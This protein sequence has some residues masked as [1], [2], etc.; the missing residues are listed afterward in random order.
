MY[1]KYIL[2]TLKNELTSFFCLL[3]ITIFDLLDIS[4]F[5]ADHYLY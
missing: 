4:I 3:F 2:H 5:S 1:K